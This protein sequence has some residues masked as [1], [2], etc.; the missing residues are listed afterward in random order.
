MALGPSPLPPFDPVSGR[1][2]KLTWAGCIVS[3]TALIRSSLNAS[4]SVSSLSLAEKVS[5]AFPASYL[6]R[7]EAPVDEG[8]DAS[9]QRVEQRCYHKGGA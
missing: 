4:R 7:L 1:S 5:K 3:L 2:H 9:P 8:L 6:L